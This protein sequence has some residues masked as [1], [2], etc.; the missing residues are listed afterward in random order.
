M[1]QSYA[2]YII[3]RAVLPFGGMI[4]GVHVS[5]NKRIKPCTSQLCPHNRTLFLIYFVNVY[6]KCTCMFTISQYFK[7]AHD[8][9]LYSIEYPYLG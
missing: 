5:E 3:A 9:G 1:R 6:M 8:L 2:L 7:H 4:Q